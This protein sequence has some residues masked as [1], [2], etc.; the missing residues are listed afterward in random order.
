M[1]RKKREEQLYFYK[2][3][4][5]G[6]LAI[7]LAV[8]AGIILDGDFTAAVVLIPMGA[9]ILITKEK[10]LGEIYDSEDEFEEYDFNE[11]EELW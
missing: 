3:R 8:I 11:N 10:L 9:Y 1:S 5:Y 4:A 7:M 2:Q 6:I